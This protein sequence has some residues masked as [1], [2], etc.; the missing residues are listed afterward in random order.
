MKFHTLF[1]EVQILTHVPVVPLN[2]Y[3]TNAYQQSNR[4]IKKHGKVSFQ[5]PVASLMY[6]G[7]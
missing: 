4:F 7:G 2:L 1:K 6:G 5:S 3:N